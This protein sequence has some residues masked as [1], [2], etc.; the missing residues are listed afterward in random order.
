MNRTI[1]LGFACLL[2]V[3]VGLP[4]SD[5]P[6]TDMHRIHNLSRGEAARHPRIL[7]EGVVTG[8]IVMPEGFWI[9]DSREGLYVINTSLKAKVEVGQ[10]LRL[11]GLADPGE[12]APCALAEKIEL[13]GQAPLPPP[14]QILSSEFASSALDSQF[15]EVKGVVRAAS[16]ATVL[17]RQALALTLDLQP[18]TF[19]VLALGAVADPAVYV[20]ATVRARGTMQ[21]DFNNRRQAVGFG[22]GVSRAEDLVILKPAP[23]DPFAISVQP[24][25]SLLQFGSDVN[26]AHRV[27]VQGVVT[28]HN[29]GSYL[30]V[31]DGAFGARVDSRNAKPLAPGTL[32][33]VAGFASPGPFSPRLDSAAIRF[34]GLGR[35][36]E[37]LERHAS[38]LTSG[39]DD[40]LLVRTKGK[41]LELGRSRGRDVLTLQDGTVRFTAELRSPSAAGSLGQLAP[42]DQVTLTGVCETVPENVPSDDRFQILLRSRADVVVIQH[43]A[44]LDLKHALWIA[45]CLGLAML[46]GSVWVWQLRKRV[47]LQTRW[48]QG[49]L[50]DEQVNAQLHIDR[51]AVFELISRDE[52]LQA[53][54]GALQSLIVRQLP[55]SSCLVL[56]PSATGDWEPVAQRTGMINCGALL[57]ILQNGKH[58]AQTLPGFARFVGFHL[59][60]I[61]VASKTGAT[62]AIVAILSPELCPRASQDLIETCRHALTLGLEQRDLRDQLIQQSFFD[63][64]TGLPNRRMFD[65]QADLIFAQA[66]RSGS[67]AALLVLDLD[68]F[69]SINDTLG[70]EAGDVFLKEVAQRFRLAVREGDIVARIGGD[71][72]IAVLPGIHGQPE[73]DVISDRLREVAAQSVEIGGIRVS[74]A[75]SIGSAIYGQDGRS[76]HELKQLADYR[77]YQSKHKSR[78]RTSRV[79]EEKPAELV[80]C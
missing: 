51:S 58:P 39:S 80:L 49:R 34:A 30:I 50:K 8:I 29:P 24:L 45:S 27:R 35:S 9:Q 63:P 13:L 38:D 37:P 41:L 68:G 78:A 65:E 59:Q 31:Q 47:R 44:W 2:A 57:E 17:G 20:D 53:I 55:Q 15:V 4:A 72:F 32:V 73:T 61:E 60:M 26:R 28:F 23:R 18:G 56:Q 10:R 33:D 67:E 7:V 54:F 36:P 43:R 75:V 66:E 6:L 25:S 71:E 76:S 70:H 12:F 64:L 19:N 40:M 77:M 69:K 3:A 1:P 22:V 79:E 52:P 46:M 48:I 11:Y 14:H 42:G 62:Q 74:A 5:A 21:V 16:Q